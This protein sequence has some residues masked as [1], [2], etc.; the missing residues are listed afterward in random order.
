MCVCIHVLMYL[1]V[2]VQCTRSHVSE[3]KWTRL[4]E[5]GREGGGR[6]GRQVS[7]GNPRRRAYIEVSNFLGL[8]VSYT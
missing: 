8:S 5:G 6:G 7:F 2:V 1:V 4:R 3:P